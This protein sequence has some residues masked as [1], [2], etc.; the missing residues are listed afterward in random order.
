MFSRLVECEVKNKLLLMYSSGLRRSNDESTRTAT[1]ASKFLKSR[2][3]CSIIYCLERENI[4]PR[5]RNELN[6]T[7]TRRYNKR[8]SL[9][10]DNRKS[11]PFGSYT[12]DISYFSSINESNHLL[13]QMR[14]KIKSLS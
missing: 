4:K 3:I 2:K 10:I 6:S 7:Q 11:K 12:I 9:P 13:G 1:L 14:D 8:M 5:N